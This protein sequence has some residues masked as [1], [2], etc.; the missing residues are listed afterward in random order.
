[1]GYSTQIIS[2]MA[3]ANIITIMAKDK[4]INIMVILSMVSNMAKGYYTRILQ[5][6]RLELMD[7]IVCLKFMKDNGE[8]GRRMDMV[9]IIIIHLIIIIKGH[10]LMI[11]NMDKMVYTVHLI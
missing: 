4:I 6:V 3:M 1:M 8:M 9:N 7:Q 11:R 10:G 2:H 5:V